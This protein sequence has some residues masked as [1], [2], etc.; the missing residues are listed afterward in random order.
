MSH[1]IGIDKIYVTIENIFT[2]YGMK[3]DQVTEN[4]VDELATAGRKYI[5]DLTDVQ[6]QSKAFVIHKPKKYQN[7][8]RKVRIPDG[9]RIKNTNYSLSHLLED[10]HIVANQYGRGYS[11]YNS[12]YNTRGK[13]THSLRMWK[14]TEDMLN[15]ELPKRIVENID[16]IK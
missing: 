10:G 7:C 5:K 12:E 3:V 8:Y 16:K 14:D 13:T 15:E 6:F 1:D 9:R 2:E 11:I 4:T